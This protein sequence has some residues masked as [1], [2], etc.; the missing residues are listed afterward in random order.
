MR[1]RGKKLYELF[2]QL[3]RADQEAARNRDANAAAIAA[4]GGTRIK[5]RTWGDS[6]NPLDQN[7]SSGFSA[8]VCFF[9]FF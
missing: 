3:Q 9:F 7:L 8:P 2:L 4:L 1:P 6:N 5:K